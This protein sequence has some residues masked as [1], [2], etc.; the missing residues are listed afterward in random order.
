MRS[1]KEVLEELAELAERS[2]FVGCSEDGEEFQFSEEINWLIEQAKKAESLESKVCEQKREIEKL[3][4]LIFQLAP[5][6]C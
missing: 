1:E 3:Q 4:A 2:Y 5:S 6:G